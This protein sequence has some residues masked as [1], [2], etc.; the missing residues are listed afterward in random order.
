MFVLYVAPGCAPPTEGVVAGTVTVDGQPA[1]IGSITFIPVDGKSKTT[2]AKFTDGKYN[3]L[4][5]L[6]KAKVQIRVSKVVGHQKL[7]NTP[8]SPVQPLME[9]VLPAKYN[10]QTELLLEVK[11][12]QNDGSYDLKSK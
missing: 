11:P 6:G 9:E 2:G 5:P 12:G 8:D 10:D 4:V 1:Q 7:Y 3:T